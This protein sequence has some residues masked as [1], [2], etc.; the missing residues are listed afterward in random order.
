MDDHTLVFAQDVAVSLGV[1]VEV[2][3]VVFPVDGDDGGPHAGVIIRTGAC[4]L[5]TYPTEEAL[6]ALADL[7]SEL[8]DVLVRE[9]EKSA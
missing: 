2:R 5:N 6:G 9:R 7:F 4:H 1:P 3:G 8:A